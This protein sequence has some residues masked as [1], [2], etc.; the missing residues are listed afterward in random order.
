M[1][2]KLKHL[3]T[4]QSFTSYGKCST[5]EENN[6]IRDHACLVSSINAKL[7]AGLLYLFSRFWSAPFKVSVVRAFMCRSSQDASIS[8]VNP[9]SLIWALMFAPLSISSL[10]M[11]LPCS[12]GY[13]CLKGSLYFWAPTLYSLIIQFPKVFVDI[14][15]AKKQT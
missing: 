14:G 7:R 1:F 6:E 11:W 13:L 5:L 15:K 8:G 12:S 2:D 10:T 3:S 9:V 4:W